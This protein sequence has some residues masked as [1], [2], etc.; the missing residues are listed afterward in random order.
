MSKTA[1]ALVP[2]QERF[3]LALSGAGANLGQLMRQN[4]D[5]ESLRAGDILDR[6]KIPSGGSTFWSVPSLDGEKAEKALEGIILSTKRRRAYWRSTDPSNNPPDCSSADC[7]HGVGKPGGDCM[8]CQLNAFGSATKKDGS[9]G[10]GKACKEV[11]QIFLLLP[12]RKLPVVI[13]ASPGSLR[14]MRDYLGKELTMQ[15]EMPCYGCITRLELSKEKSADGIE[16]SRIKP[17]FVEQLGE[18][19]MKAVAAYAASLASVFEATEIHG[20]DAE[21]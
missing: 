19:E 8:A 7:L 11:R 1:T 13:G 18:E 21:G 6:I 3:K 16:Y 20:E 9:A 14:V 12:G 17:S 2:F 10:A 5:G 4:L 15:R